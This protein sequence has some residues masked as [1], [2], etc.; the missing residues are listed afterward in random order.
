MGEF[1]QSAYIHQ[2][3]KEHYDRM[4]F[5]LPKGKGKAVKRL[6]VEK[7]VSITQLIVYALEKVYDLDLSNKD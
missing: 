6:A 3:Q 7:G 4:S 1:D 5:L 2:Y